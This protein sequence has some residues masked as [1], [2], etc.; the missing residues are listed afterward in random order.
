MKAIVYRNYGSPDVLQ[1]EEMDKPAPGN[2]EVLIKVR[3]ASV[4]PYDWH[5]M[6]G[7]PYPLR[8]ASGLSKPKDKRLGV[9]V[10]GQVEAAGGRVTQLKPGD[11]VFGCARGAFAEYAC[12]A[13]TKLVPKPENVTLE[14]AASAP[15]AGLT[16]LQGLRRGGLGD[17]G[18]VESGPRVLI[19]GAAGGV[20]TF[21]VEIAKCFGAEVT[22]VCSTKNVEMV[23]SI[24]AD[25]VIDYT[26]EDFTTS[27]ERYDLILDCMANHSLSAVRSVLKA[28]G[29]YVMVGAMD[30]GG[31]WMTGM[32]ARL[33]KARALSS[34]VGQKLVMVQA[35]I[36]K[37]DLTF[38]GQLMK[39]GKV[40]P[41]IDRRNGLHELPGAIR[42]LEQGHA[43]GKVVITL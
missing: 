42:Y 21:A 13:E 29:N 35:N 36:N 1:Y 31:R 7:K 30:G 34:L 28:K 12:G 37:E 11:E 27:G 8:I 38:L 32:L 5:L 4:N 3:A 25:H 20:G 14:Q 9:D 10:A 39:T 23:R 19:N 2:G 33:F 24:G 43:R 18:G 16:A 6:R 17:R 26:A 22:G 15:I 41:V 40:T